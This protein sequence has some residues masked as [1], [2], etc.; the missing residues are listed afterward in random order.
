[1]SESET[2]FEQQHLIAALDT[3][4]PAIGL[5]LVVIVCLY[6]AM[7][8]YKEFTADT[9]MKSV[10]YEET[11]ISGKYEYKLPDDEKVCS[12]ECRFCSYPYVGKLSSDERIFGVSKEEWSASSEWCSFGDHDGGSEEYRAQ[13]DG[14]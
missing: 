4:L 9:R 8:A 6:V 10:M 14:R 1:M 3:S 13:E 11:G 7:R 2:V 12:N 5:A